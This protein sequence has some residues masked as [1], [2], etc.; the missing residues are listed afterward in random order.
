MSLY[1]V[2]CKLSSEAIMKRL[3]LSLLLVTQYSAVACAQV[4][5][6]FSVELV[7]ISIDGV[8][9]LQSYAI[10]QHNGQWLV[11][12]GRTEGIHARQ[13]HSSFP[14]ANNNSMMYV[15][16]INSRQVWSIPVDSLPTTISEQLQS[17]NMQFLQDGEQ[18]IVTGGYAF[19]KSQNRH[20]TY[21]YITVIDVP[22]AINAIVGNQ[23]IEQHITQVEDEAFALTGGQLGKLGEV[24]YLVGGHRFDGRYNPHGP[25]HGMGFKQEYSN[26]IRKFLLTGSGASLSIEHLGVQRDEDHLRRRD[27]NLL[28]QVFD[29]G[30]EGLTISSGVFQKAVDLPFLYPV[31]ITT[32]GYKPIE[33]FSQLLSNYHS[34]KVSLYSSS[35]NQMHHIFFGG[36]SQYYLDGGN[37]VK[38]DQVPFVRTI[39]RLTRSGSGNWEEVAL[40]VEMPGLVGAGAEFILNTDL[41]T[42]GSRTLNLDLLSRDGTV[43]GYVYG[44]ISSPMKHAFFDYETA[45]TN[46]ESTIYEVRLV[47]SQSS[48][49]IKVGIKSN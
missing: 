19:S 28:P 18:L 24:Y 40:P 26:E 11:V 35:T 7:P 25:D 20:I 32:D 9:G 36:I 4:N 22:G 29:D 21:P 39:S 2:I 23:A 44:G 38:D 15:I 33:G 3:L 27:F 41:A 10:A 43:L 5:D 45:K 16:D 49:N 37:L 46:A 14:V 31:E 47:A 42:N 17:T 13:G 12:G 34:A 6:D 8:P 48:K 1:W 30:S